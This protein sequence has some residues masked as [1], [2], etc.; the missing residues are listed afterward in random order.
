VAV[1]TNG[2]ELVEVFA[3]EIETG[4]ALEALARLLPSIRQKR[5]VFIAKETSS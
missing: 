3:R 5:D 1:G 2:Q 4:Q